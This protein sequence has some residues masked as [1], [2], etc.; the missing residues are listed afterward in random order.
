MHDSDPL[1]DS[2]PMH[3]SDPLHDLGPGADLHRARA[4]RRQPVAFVGRPPYRGPT[5]RS[6]PSAGGGV[7]DTGLRQ[8][9]PWLDDVSTPTSAGHG[10]DRLPTAVPDPEVHRDQVGPLD[11]VIDSLSGHGTFI[12]GLVHQVCPDADIVSWRVVPSR[13]RSSSP[14]SSS[15]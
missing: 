9:T 13:D 4:R 3:D 1:H 12:A 10:S 14:S 15:R 2:G 8:A 7:L 6:G 11:G 5:R